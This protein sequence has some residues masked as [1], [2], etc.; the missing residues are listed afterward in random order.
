ML[1]IRA[2]YWGDTIYDCAERMVNLS[3]KLDVSVIVEFNNHD[4]IAF[5]ESKQEEVI[6]QYRHAC[7]HIS[8]E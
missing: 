2:E 8:Q 5:P 3:K 6:T 1:Q 4:L 7:K